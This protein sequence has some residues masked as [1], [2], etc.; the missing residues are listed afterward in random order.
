MLCQ[1]VEASA[2]AANRGLQRRSRFKSEPG[3]WNEQVDPAVICDAATSA[4][5]E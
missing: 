5:Q 1:L 2:R 4:L 3:F